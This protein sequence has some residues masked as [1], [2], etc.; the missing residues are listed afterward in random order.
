MQQ[1]KLK[2]CIDMTFLPNV[3]KINLK[4]KDNLFIL[5]KDSSFL[6]PL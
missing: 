1:L 6:N 2:H 5:L 3:I 4:M